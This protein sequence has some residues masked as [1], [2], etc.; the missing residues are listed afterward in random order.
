MPGRVLIPS[1][2]KEDPMPMIENAT[3]KVLCPFCKKLYFPRFDSYEA[4][5][6]T[7]DCEAREQWISGCCSNSCRDHSLGLPDREDE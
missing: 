7:R 3:G 5:M 4:A 1:Y 6:K 2:T